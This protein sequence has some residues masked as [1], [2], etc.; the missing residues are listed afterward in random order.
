VTGARREPLWAST[1]ALGGVCLVVAAGMVLFHLR[2][3][4]GP[5]PWSGDAQFFF[6]MAAEWPFRPGGWWQYRILAPFIVHVLPL[7]TNLGYALLA[8]LSIGGAGAALVSLLRHLGYGPGARALGAVL[9]LSSFAVLYNSWNYAMPDPLA[10]LLL[11][12]ACRAMVRGRDAELAVWLLLGALGKEVVLYVLPA[13]WLWGRRSGLDLREALRTGL[14]ALP[15]AAA[16]LYLRLQP[17]EATELIGFVSG[18]AWLYPWKHQPEN[19]SRLYSPFAAGWVLAILSFRRPDRYGIAALGFA[20]PCLLSLLMTDAGR[21]LAYLTPFAVPA[22]L[23]GAGAGATVSRRSAAALLLAALSM[24]LWEPF[25]LFWKVPILLRRTLAL[26]LAP[27]CAVL[28]FRRPR[29]SAS[30]GSR[31]EPAKRNAG[32][33]SP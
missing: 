22:M 32:G 6:R 11:T 27:V 3:E 19:V 7:G 2:P 24:R 21:M 12:L 23:R 14:V 4:D 31:P 29:D 8:A 25:A 16:F 10:L 20:V 17:G 18:D 1:P 9:Y 30:S 15:A 33:T 28:A 26:L 13:R 5:G